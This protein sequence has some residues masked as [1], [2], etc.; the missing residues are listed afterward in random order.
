M[1]VLIPR[2]IGQTV[3]LETSAGTSMSGTLFCN[4]ASTQCV[5]LQQDG[6]ATIRIVSV[7][8]VTRALAHA[9]TFATEYDEKALPPLPKLNADKINEREQKTLNRIKR[10]TSKIGHNVTP[11]AQSIFN[12]LVKT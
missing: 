12:A 7:P 6:G 1:S 11:Q 3:E 2:R 5:V 10:E 9:P 4:D 8:C